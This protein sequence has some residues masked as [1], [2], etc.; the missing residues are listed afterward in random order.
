MYP[1]VPEE[2]EKNDDGFCITRKGLNN[3]FLMSCGTGR[4]QIMTG[5]LSACKTKE[6]KKQR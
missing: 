5:S 2:V 3:D 4:T 1:V 6:Y